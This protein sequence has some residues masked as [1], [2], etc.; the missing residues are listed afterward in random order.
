M[1]HEKRMFVFLIA[2]VNKSDCAPC[3]TIVD[4][5]FCFFFFFFLFICLLFFPFGSTFNFLAGSLL[6]LI[7]KK[8]FELSSQHEHF[9]VDSGTCGFLAVIFWF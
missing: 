1:S 5:F 3:W 4:G 2:V 7:K 9:K 6:F 8:L